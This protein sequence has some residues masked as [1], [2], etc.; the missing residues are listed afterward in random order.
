M[1]Q[2]VKRVPTHGLFPS[3]RFLFALAVRSHDGSGYHG[4]VGKSDCRSR[5]PCW[6]GKQLSQHPASAVIVLEIK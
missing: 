6:M 5:E 4:R 3:V 1:S 2:C